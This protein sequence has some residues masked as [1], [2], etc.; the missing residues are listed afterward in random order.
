MSLAA[1]FLIIGIAVII[2]GLASFSWWKEMEQLLSLAILFIG[3]GIVVVALLVSFIHD[4]IAIH[5][6]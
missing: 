3:G 2:F 4:H 5:F 6:K 1:I